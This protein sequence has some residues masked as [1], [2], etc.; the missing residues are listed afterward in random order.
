[1]AE[2][3]LLSSAYFPPISY[4]SIIY[5]A[6]NVLIEKE[7]NY[8]KQTYRNRCKILTA[9]GPT[10]LTV[11]VLSGG[12]KKTCIKDIRI[13]YSKRWQQVHL[14][15]LTSAYSSS[16]FFEYFFDLVEKL[17]SDKEKYLFDLNMKSL[18]I[19]LKILRIT[20]P[21]ECTNI[22]KPVCNDNQDFRY[23][24]SPKKIP[25]VTH[26]K[27]YYQVFGNKYGFISDLS[28]LDLIFNAGSD[29]NNYLA[30]NEK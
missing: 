9:N 20:T 22:F 16:A 6:D 18:E 24:I 30:G 21:V 25:A 15:A 10:V 26:L 11:P 1:M 28:V 4:I 8:L 3:Y 2:N 5:R 17:I 13:D 7:E 14:R 12:Q 19:V 27:E 23:K 29:S